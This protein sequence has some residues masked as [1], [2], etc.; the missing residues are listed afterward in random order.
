[1]LP[2][3]ELLELNQLRS[4][5]M[6]HFCVLVSNCMKGTDAPATAAVVMVFTT[7][8]PA[9]PLVVSILVPIVEIMCGVVVMLVAEDR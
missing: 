1:M 4:E 7:C 6:V 3:P 5:F 9:D 8:I 2:A